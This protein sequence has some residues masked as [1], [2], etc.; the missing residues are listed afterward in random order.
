[1]LK[2]IAVIIFL[3]LS[4]V[5]YL[6]PFNTSESSQIFLSVSTFLF[7]IFTG[8]FIARQ[9]KRYSSIRDQITKFDGEMS[10][11]Y[12]QFGHLGKINSKHYKLI[13]E[14]QAW[15]YH[16]VNKSTTL[17]AIHELVEKTTKNKKLASLKNLALQRIL[18]GLE[19]YSFSLV[20]LIVSYKW[21]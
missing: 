17:I 9:G 14:K 11:I 19:R 21:V 3:V 6:I 13:L 7:A 12:R 16:F 5:Y 1:M 4:S 15:D 18:F 10:S 8:F 2:Y 20:F